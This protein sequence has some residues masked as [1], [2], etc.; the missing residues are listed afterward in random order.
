MKTK[1]SAYTLVELIVSITLLAIIIGIFALIFVQGMNQLA[2]AYQLHNASALAE[3]YLN[4]VMST[5]RWDEASSRMASEGVCVPLTVASLG[6]EESARADYDDCDDYN[7]FTASG[8]H[9]FKN[10][11]PMNPAFS[12]YSAAI[13]VNFVQFGETTPSSTPTNIK[14]ITVSIKWGANNSTVLS[15]VLTNI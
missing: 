15:T 5:G 9:K 8:G 1:S 3:I 7:G 13:K 4:E 12:I 11:E 6:A 14:R 10:G 2:Y